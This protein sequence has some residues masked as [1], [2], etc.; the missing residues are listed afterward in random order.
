MAMAMLLIGFV[1]LVGTPV[2]Q[3]WADMDEAL[4]SISSP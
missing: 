4:S 3:A 2:R 1:V